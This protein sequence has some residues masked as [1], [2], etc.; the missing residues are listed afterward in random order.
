M[1]I[2]PNENPNQVTLSVDREEEFTAIAYS[3][4]LIDCL[5]LSGRLNEEY[6]IQIEVSAR[7]LP[8]MINFLLTGLE[9]IEAEKAE[10][11]QRL[12]GQLLEFHESKQH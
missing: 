12:G 1:E 9:R 4:S 3:G 6:P 7:K 8:R 2:T 5:R 11:Y 10:L